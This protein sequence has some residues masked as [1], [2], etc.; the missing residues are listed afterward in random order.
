M[1]L[2]SAFYNTGQSALYSAF[3]MRNRGPSAIAW[4]SLETTNT[5]KQ[6]TKKQTKP[7][8]KPPS[9]SS[10]FLSLASSLLFP[11]LSLRT[12]MWPLFLSWLAV[13][14]PLISLRTCCG[15]TSSVVVVPASRT[16]MYHSLRKRTTTTKNLSV[17]R[18]LFQR[19]NT[20][21]NL[22][23]PTF[24]ESANVSRS[25]PVAFSSSSQGLDRRSNT[26][27]TTKMAAITT[28]TTA[29][30]GGGRGGGGASASTAPGEPVPATTINEGCSKLRALRKKM[31]ALNLDVYIVPSDDPH[32]SEYVPD[33]YKRRAYLSGFTVRTF[34][35]TKTQQ[36]QQNT[37]TA[38]SR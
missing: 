32:L 29:L 19:R 27:G 26:M 18:T 24:F 8:R 34:S 14:S 9:V 2:Y 11:V 17:I 7:Q 31:H 5:F 36:K 10:R 12:C 4:S 38:S 21:S 3:Y 13:F 22:R 20:P 33:A 37:P 25:L 16:W 35:V 23:Y 6:R 1:S 30:R 28:T 15:W